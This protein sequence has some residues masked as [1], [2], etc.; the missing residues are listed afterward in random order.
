MPSAL[1]TVRLLSSLEQD[2]TTGMTM[3]A[4]GARFR[5]FMKSAREVGVLTHHGPNPLL[6]C[7]VGLVQSETEPVHV[8][9]API[10]FRFRGDIV[11]LYQ[12]VTINFGKAHRGERDAAVHRQRATPASNILHAEAITFKLHPQRQPSASECASPGECCFGV[13]DSRVDTPASRV[14]PRIPLTTVQVSRLAT[15]F[16]RSQWKRLTLADPAVFCLLR[17]VI[18]NKCPVD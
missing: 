8:S 10:V 1:L 18:G 13:P 2:A 4:K 9:L 17:G 7:V 16:R 15:V 3:M 6:R 14:G 12:S 5:I 11:D